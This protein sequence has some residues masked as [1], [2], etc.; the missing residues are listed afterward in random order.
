MSVDLN[1]QDLSLPLIGSFCD[2]VLLFR[3]LI[4]G[5]EFEFSIRE[6]QKHSHESEKVILKAFPVK[7]TS[8]KQPH[9]QKNLHYFYSVNKECL[10]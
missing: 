2:K 3:R 8:H 6:Q 1:P 4:V 10:F 7:L 9:I 5:S